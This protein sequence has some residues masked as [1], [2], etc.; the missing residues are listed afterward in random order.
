MAE[1]YYEPWTGYV[2]VSRRR[3]VVCESY[4]EALEACIIAHIPDPEEAIALARQEFY[5]S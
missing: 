4:E 2:V 3:E 5:E 1:I